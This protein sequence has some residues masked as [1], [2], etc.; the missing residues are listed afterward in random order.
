MP[1]EFRG[2]GL[3]EQQPKR[4]APVRCVGFAPVGI[5]LAGDRW[6]IIGVATTL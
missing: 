3:L 5:F 4:V 1:V 6:L 2:V